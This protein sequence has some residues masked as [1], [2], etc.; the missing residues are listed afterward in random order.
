[1]D[2]RTIAPTYF[3]T[4]HPFPIELEALEHSIY[5]FPVAEFKFPVFFTPCPQGSRTAASLEMR[6][7]CLMPRPPW[8]AAVFAFF[9]LLGASNFRALKYFPVEHQIHAL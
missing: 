3:R 6:L 7:T 4:G 9:S 1:M 2:Y 5:R 8:H